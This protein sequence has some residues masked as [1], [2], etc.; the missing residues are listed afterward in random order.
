MKKLL[1]ISTTNLFSN[2]R[3]VKELHYFSEKGHQISAIVFKIGYGDIESTKIESTLTNVNFIHLSAL[4]K[5]FFTW[6]FSSI[7]SSF[8]IKIWP[9][10]KTNLLI[11]SYASNK[12]SIIIN[13]Y[14][15]AH[16]DKH[17]LAIAHT[18]GALYPAYIY[19]KKNN[20]ILGFDMEDYHPGEL[21]K[22]NQKEE[23][24]RRKFILKKI[25]PSCNYTS[26]ASPLFI[27]ETNCLL[28]KPLKNQLVIHNSFSASEFSYTDNS[29]E[30][31]SLI[32]YS[33]TIAEGRGLELILPLIEKNA[34]HLEL[35]LI[36]NLDE[37]FDKK[38]NITNAKHINFLGSLSQK[39]LHKELCKAD[40]GLSLEQKSTDLNR[41]LC[42]TN[43]II[44]YCQAGIYIFATAT[45]AQKKLIG[46]YPELGIISTNFEKDF[47]L[48][49]KEITNIRANKQ[50]RFNI[51]NKL[52]WEIEQKKYENII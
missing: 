26:Y 43:K 39:E 42:L 40:V 33:L 44:S 36:G 16:S 24:A 47:P 20:S 37:N 30:K 18:L 46:D 28:K 2:P 38:F 7:I 1:F 10:F 3:L 48:M 15:A 8:L 32:W 21:I 25:I 17:D 5:P 34:D 11:S 51:G 4:K 45:Q 22:Q 12:R 13:Q 29:S 27:D 9:L 49:I 50:A 6:F 19:S 31:I 23:E 41:D 52:S 14:L 35:T